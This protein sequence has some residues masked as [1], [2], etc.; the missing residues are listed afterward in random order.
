MKARLENTPPRSAKDPVVV[1]RGKRNAARFGILNKKKV[2]REIL[3]KHRE[4]RYF[5]VFD[6]PI[7]KV[8][9][10]PAPFRA[11]VSLFC[12]LVTL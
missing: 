8:R 7:S 2:N 10:A 1:V 4:S 6:S 5:Y 11:R 12:E 9:V 3:V